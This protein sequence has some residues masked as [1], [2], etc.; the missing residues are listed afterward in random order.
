M[1]LQSII[2]NSSP[3]LLCPRNKRTQGSPLLCCLLL[4]VHNQFSLVRGG[5]LRHYLILVRPDFNPKLTD[6][7]LHHHDSIRQL[8]GLDIDRNVQSG[9]DCQRGS[10]SWEPVQHPANHPNRSARSSKRCSARPSRIPSFVASA[11]IPEP[12]DPRSF[13]ARPV[14]PITNTAATAYLL[15]DP[16]RA[17]DHRVWLRPVSGAE[18]G[19]QWCGRL[20]ILGG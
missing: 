2:I 10:S 8:P 6:C 13:P 7:P 4:K 1:E 12:P 5:N 16:A 11:D 15:P 18:R 3:L 17:M 14:A 20:S 19:W 9:S